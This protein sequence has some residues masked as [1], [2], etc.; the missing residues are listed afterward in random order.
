MIFGDPLALVAFARAHSPYFAELYRELP[1]APSWWQIPVVDPEHYWASKAEDFDATLSGPAD[2]G[3]WLASTMRFVAREAQALRP[4]GETVI[5]RLA[6]VLVIQLIRTWID[7]ASAAGR[8]WL[9]ALRDPQLGAALNAIHRSPGAPWSVATLAEQACMS[10]SAFAARFTELVGEPVG[11]YL[12]SWRLRLARERLRAGPVA[13]AAVADELGYRSEAAFCR[14]FK[15]EFGV[16]PGR[17]R[18][19][20]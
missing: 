3:S 7:S 9:G 18:R 16:S 8:G 17:S 5:T 12:T 15:R 2:A 4:G 20:E 14:A 10:R 11:R 6:D 13:I 1:A 19:Q